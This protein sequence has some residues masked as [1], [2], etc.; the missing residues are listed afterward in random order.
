[1]RHRKSSP[2]IEEPVINITPLIDVVF[3]VLIMFILIAP[4]VDK[5]G[6]ELAR[7]GEGEAREVKETSPIAVVVKKNSDIFLNRV[8]LTLEELPLRLI[9]AKQSFPQA[10]P[11]LFHDKMAPFGTYQEVKLAMEAAGFNEMELVLEPPGQPPQ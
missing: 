7:G 6:V 8:P 9:Q 10:V 3:V 1:M 4:L 2:P 5:E 11:Q